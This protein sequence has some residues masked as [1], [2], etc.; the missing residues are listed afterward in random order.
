MALRAT[1]GD[2]KLRRPLAYARGS[3]WGFVRSHETLTEPRP[4]GAVIFKGRGHFSNLPGNRPT[5]SIG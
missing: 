2:E 5:S 4:E 1:E 3:V